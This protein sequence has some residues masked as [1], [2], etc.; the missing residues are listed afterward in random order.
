MLS[1]AQEIDEAFD[2]FVVID[3]LASSSGLIW[4]GSLQ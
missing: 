2:R 3:P 4:I 1:F